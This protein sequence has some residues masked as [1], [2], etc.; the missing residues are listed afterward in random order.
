[1]SLIMGSVNSEFRYCPGIKSRDKP[2]L[3][4]RND[5]DITG[6]TCHLQLP[7]ADVLGEEG[8]ET[9]EENIYKEKY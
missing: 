6:H 2:E 4:E 5:T 1:M 9:T 8:V 7:F 3:I